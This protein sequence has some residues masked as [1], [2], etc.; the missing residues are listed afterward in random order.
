MQQVAIIVKFLRGAKN[1]AQ[2][3]F[4][5]QHAAIAGIFTCWNA[6]NYCSTL[7]AKLHSTV[8]HETTSKITAIILAKCTNFTII[9][10]C[11]MQ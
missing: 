3:F 9:A 2:L 7:H 1:I 4:C 8:A 11:C 5:V 10:E 6:Y